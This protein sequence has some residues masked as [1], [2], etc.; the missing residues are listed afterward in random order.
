M[1]YKRVYLSPDAHATVLKLQE[2]I[3]E[4]TGFETHLTNIVGVLA[5]AELERLGVDPGTAVFG[6]LQL[7]T[8]KAARKSRNK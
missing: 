6:K 8:E 5:K 1:N 2:K 7:L 3:H 4:M